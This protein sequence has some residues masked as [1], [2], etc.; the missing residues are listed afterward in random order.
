MSRLGITELLIV[1]I[2]VLIIVGVAAAFIALLVVLLRKGRSDDASPSNAE[3]RDENQ[4]LQD[5]LAAAKKQ[6]T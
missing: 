4:R 2:I 1:L 3:L 5:E 6:K